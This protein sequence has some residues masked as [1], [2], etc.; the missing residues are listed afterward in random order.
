MKRLAA[1][2]LVVLV[3][4]PVGA[5]SA[6]S[7]SEHSDNMSLIGN[8]TVE[9]YAGSDLA[10][11]GDMAVLGSY[12]APGGFE[13]L[14]IS[15]PSQPR[16]IGTFNCPGTQNDVSIWGDIVVMS[17]DSP[18]G[19]AD[20]GGKPVTPET[21]G[22]GAAS[23]DQ[24]ESGSA[25]E[26]LRIVSI[27][28]R[29][30]PV[31]LATV[32]TDCGSHTHTLVPDTANGRLYAYVLSYPLGAPSPSCNVV[33]HRKISIVEIPLVNPAGAKLAGTFDVSP[34][35]GCHDLTVFLPRMIA[36]AA[37]ISESQIWDIKD[38]AKPRILS[39]IRNPRNNIHHSSTFSWDG[40]VMVLGD[41]LGGAVA[42]PGC[43]G[44]ENGNLGGLWFYDVKD[45]ASPVLRGEYR[46]PQQQESPAD[47]CTAHLF[48]VVPLRSEKN[49]LVASWYTAGTTVVDFTD[50]TSPRQI[51]YY[52]PRDPVSTGADPAPNMWS[53][54]WYNGNV[55][56]NNHV[57]RGF[58]VFE[59]RDPVFDPQIKL[60]RLNPQ[61]QEPLPAPVA[62]GTLG[63]P[64]AAPANRCTKRSGFRVRLRPPRGQRLR[65]AVIF[66]GG[67]RAKVVKGRALRRP[68]RLSG[69]KR[70]RVR[71]DVTLRTTRG[72]T[73]NR[74]RTYR[75]C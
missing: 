35:I 20:A 32:K 34:A 10:F 8:W 24:I 50:P 62:A 61:I 9:D 54:Y 1:V 18:R 48:N 25:W 16:H 19:T 26:G 14:D 57:A 30:K 66:V 42:S 12:A 45:A 5:A 15:A 47:I 23:Q 58:D 55:Y 37:C 70:G 56:A 21:C 51:A 75:F 67:R 72:R 29:S 40:N 43:I 39:R 4:V 17:V 52:V 63:L 11:W 60:P 7:A 22:A 28:D 69:L 73:V 2:L 64:A 31:Q 3:A 68:V 65:S 27:A 13:M 36:G 6:Q 59:I 46:I 44:S 33:S 41:E 49:I 74:S 38:P 71:I 53:A